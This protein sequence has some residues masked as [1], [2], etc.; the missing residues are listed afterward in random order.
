MLVIAVLVLSPSTASA[1]LKLCPIR[2]GISFCTIS[3]VLFFIR[4]FLASLIISPTDLSAGC[5][6]NCLTGSASGELS[7]TVSR[8]FLY[9]V[10]SPGVPPSNPATLRA[11]IT[12]SESLNP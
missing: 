6:S 5:G 4:V 1:S 12:A 2:F 11:C 8:N 9:S 7:G 3:T 10:C